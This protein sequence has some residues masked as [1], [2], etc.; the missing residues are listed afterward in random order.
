MILVVCWISY[1]C[2]FRIATEINSCKFQYELFMLQ[3]KKSGELYLS[4]VLFESVIHSELYMLLNWL[5]FNLTMF[6]NSSIHIQGSIELFSF[7]SVNCLALHRKHFNL[8]LLLMLNF[9]TQ[10]LC[11]YRNTK[12]T[13]DL[14]KLI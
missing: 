5:L 10:L 12:Q 7:A 2:A 9:Y 4:I 11:L 1:V 3:K 13:K 14:N 6:G 8:R